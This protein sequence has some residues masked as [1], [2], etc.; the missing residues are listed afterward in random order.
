MNK[1]ID[2]E[3]IVKDFLDKTKLIYKN[4]TLFIK[5]DFLLKNK[6]KAHNLE[7]HI[8][9]FQRKNKDLDT[10]DIIIN[11]DENNK[12]KKVSLLK[13]RHLKSISK[14]RILTKIWKIKNLL[15]DCEKNIFLYNEI[16][17][18]IKQMMWIE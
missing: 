1:N 6:Y 12:L 18:K 15:I 16:D 3:I 11:P 10:F 14:K 4:F 7:N 8:E 2:L 5:N 9:K 13:T 17:K